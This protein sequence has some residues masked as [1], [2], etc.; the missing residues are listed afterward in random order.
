MHQKTDRIH[1]PGKSPIFI[2]S[3]NLGSLGEQ[4]VRTVLAQFQGV[5]LQVDLPIEIV[6][7]VHHREK[8][9]QAVTEAAT[10]RGIIVHTIVNPNLRQALINEAHEQNV[11]AIDVVGPLLDCLAGI[12][13]Q[14]P[15]G[16]PGLYRQLHKTYFKRIEAIEYTIAHNDG[17]KFQEWPQAE[18]VLLGVSRVGKTPLS[19][20]LSM[21]GWKVANIPLI[22]EIPPRAEL[23][24]LDSC[25]VVGLTMDPSQLLHHRRHRR[26]RLGIQGRSAYDSPQKLYEELEAARHIMRRGRFAIIDVTNKP[27]ETSADQVI[28]KVTRYQEKGSKTKDGGP[29]MV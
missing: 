26:S 13:D 1:P 4:L 28:D 12:L 18:I 22:P 8:I 2:I 9:E 7:R 11:V 16:K 6:P 3:G 25:R 24:Q 19:L 10:R 21:L 14:E 27:I 29:P 17:L 5:D 15:I 20:Y 23:F